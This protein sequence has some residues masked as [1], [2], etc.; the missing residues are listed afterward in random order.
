MLRQAIALAHGQGALTWELRAAID[1]AEL[2]PTD[3]VE[4]LSAVYGR[5]TEGFERPDLTRAR[6]LLENGL[7]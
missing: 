4:L 3:G 6:R 2:R 5:F 7:S 1:L